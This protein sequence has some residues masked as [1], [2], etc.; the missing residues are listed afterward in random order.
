MPPA[1]TCECGACS[2]CRHRAYMR[3]WYRRQSREKR[4]AIGTRTRRNDPDGVRARELRRHH[5][6][7][8]SDPDYLAKR[9]ARTALNNAIRAGRIGREVCEVCGDPETHGHHH[10]Y[11]RPL[12]VRWLCR[13]HHGHE[14]RES[15]T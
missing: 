1:R 8:A 10:D 11:T 15:A 7:K 14:H 6:R 12:E 13:E 3:E 9:R 5:E 2:K 4:Q